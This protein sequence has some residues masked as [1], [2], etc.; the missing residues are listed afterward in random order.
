LAALPH[1]SILEGFRKAVYNPAMRYPHL[2]QP[3]LLALL[4]GPTST[5]LAQDAPVACK[6]SALS[7]L[8]PMPNFRYRCDPEL[9]S[10]DEKILKLPARMRAKQT[11][12]AQLDAFVTPAWWRAKV[13]DLNACDFRHK[14]G[15][16]AGDQLKQ[17]KEGEYRFWLFGEDDIR[18][19]LLPD[20][21]Y[22]SDYNG[23]VAFVLYHK[24]G[25]VYV[26]QVLD[27]FFSRAD[28]PLLFQLAKDGSEE[29][30]EVATWS[31]GLNPTVT[32][33]YFAIDPKTN[34]AAPRN[35]FAGDKGPTNEIS[36]AMLF[37]ASED[38][39]EPE[40]L[41]VIVNNH[42]AK[43]FSIYSDDDAG[44]IDDNGRK[45][46]RTVLTWNGKMYK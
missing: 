12:M 43:S 41:K 46:T 24:G 31:G 4:F 13:D 35:L 45:L 37:G 3:L 40:A 44:T 15:V 19:V 38:A 8:K 10:Y 32:N 9:Q 14:P 17:F 23:S 18:L 33:Y 2:I 28:N 34:R 29:I 5:G 42:L 39:E 25:K 20:P 21:C 7:A 11:L 26:S 27:N 1:C 16:L 22:Q 30:L 36:S 6:Q